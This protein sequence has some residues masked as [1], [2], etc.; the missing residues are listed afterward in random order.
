MFVPIGVENTTARAKISALPVPE[1]LRTRPLVVGDD[2]QC[3]ALHELEAKANEIVAIYENDDPDGADYEYDVDVTII[4]T[5]MVRAKSQGEAEEMAKKD[6]ERRLYYGETVE[7]CY[8]TRKQK[9][10]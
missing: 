7:D 10:V 9:I 5:V 2:E 6:V 1:V 8:V 3:K 4:K